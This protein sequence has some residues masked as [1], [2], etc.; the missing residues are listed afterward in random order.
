MSQP[1]SPAAGSELNPSEQALLR[2][3]EQQQQL[4]QAQQM[5][6][7]SL[8]T[9]IQRKDE[10]EGL[11][12]V[13]AVGKPE[14][15]SGTKEEIKTKWPLWSFQF[16]T[17]FASQWTAGEA[18]LKWSEKQ[19][20]PIDDAVLSAKALAENWLDAGKANRQLH[21]AL[22]S[23]TKGEALSMMRNAVSGSG[24][25]GWRKLSR[26]YEPNTA[27]SNYRLLGKILHP[28]SVDLK[29]LRSSLETWE[30]T[31]S[32]YVQRTSD[33]LTDPTRRLCLQAQCP[34]S[35]Q[36]HLEL[37]AARLSTY[38]LMRSEVEAY[39]DVKLSSSSTGL[40]PMDVDTVQRKETRIC[41]I[42]G[43][44]G[45][46]AKDCWH[47]KSD[48]HQSFGGPSSS[49]KV[50]K[51]N[52][53][54]KG[55]G[56]GKE[57]GKGGKAKGKG[58]AE[59]KGYGKKDG[60]KDVKALDGEVTDEQWHEGDGYEGWGDW[61]QEA[62]PAQEPPGEVGILF[63]LEMDEVDF[64][65]DESSSSPGGAASASR[66]KETETHPPEP[67]K[68]GSSTCG[69]RFFQNTVSGTE[70]RNLQIAKSQ[71]ASLAQ[72]DPARSEVEARIAKHTRTLEQLRE[73]KGNIHT[74]PRYQRDVVEM[75][76]KL[77]KRKWKSRQRAKE[78]RA[79]TAKQRAEQNVAAQE[80]WQQHIGSQDREKY[81]SHG[82]RFDGD[83]PDLQPDM[84]SRPLTRDET[85]MFLQEGDEELPEVRPRS[86]EKP[87]WMNRRGEQA[88]H[89]HLI[90]SRNRL[91]QLKKGRDKQKSWGSDWNWDGG[92]SS[93][94][95]S[96]EEPGNDFNE[97]HGWQDWGYD[98]KSGS[99]SSTR[100]PVTPPK[101]MPKTPPIR[102]NEVNDTT[103]QETS[104]SGRGG[105]PI[106]ATTSE[107]NLEIENAKLQRELEALRH[108]VVELRK[109]AMPTGD[110]DDS[111][112]DSLDNAERPEGINSL[113]AL[114]G[115]AWDGYKEIEVTVDSGSAVSGLPEDMAEWVPLLKAIGEEKPYTSA[116]NHSVKV[117]GFRQP[118]FYF[119]PGLERRVRMTVL[120][121][122]K[123]PI[124]STAAMT[125]AGMK[126]VH[127][128]EAN[129]GSYVLDRKSG[130]RI[131]LYEKGGVYKIRVW[132][133]CGNEGPDSGFPGQAALP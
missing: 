95:G 40:A 111:S 76:Q 89:N 45:H 70:Q 61:S 120:S 41:H 38:D 122:L 36:E 129:G 32:E 81:D 3:V 96:W 79:K 60:R 43:K 48:S 128:N 86:K 2:I 66:P 119:E 54:G 7:D 124:F 46:L 24:V 84:V 107:P 82:G 112:L 87:S 114:D 27:Q 25:D 71:L 28:K 110:T 1:G 127:D 108:A 97:W 51:G 83:R 29:D 93:A 101:A 131:P 55:K 18:M 44:Q 109:S 11:I 34:A 9:L 126:V 15:L 104:S 23:L 17:W 132:I 5:Q 14:V 37:H 105:G 63:A 117:L 100:A 35:L 125:K 4:M 59:A 133:K 115:Q 116:S 68:T 16:I 113:D 92:W 64:G 42:C 91:N 33:Q 98:R 94:T 73:E 53:K 49:T 10:R 123:K 65:E 69:I 88:K 57:K 56:K 90:K 78:H 19:T 39:L 106:R 31:Y 6:I 77:A 118:T 85:Q 13:K 102:L 74:D 26:E 50:P 21:V 62:E 58:K 103:C 47:K 72:D 52:L 121:P 75:G 67:T 22:V 8:K 30:K 80:R 12:D 20:G 99:S 130:V